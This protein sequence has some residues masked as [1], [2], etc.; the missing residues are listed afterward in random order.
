MRSVLS[1][2]V[3]FE[4]GIRLRTFCM[5]FWPR[6]RPFFRCLGLLFFVFMICLQEIYLNMCVYWLYVQIQGQIS[7]HFERSWYTYTYIHIQ[8]VSSRYL[9]PENSENLIPPAP[10][11]LKTYTSLH[12]PFPNPQSFKN[13]KQPTQFNKNPNNPQTFQTN[14][15]TN[16]GTKS[17]YF[18]TL[19]DSAPDYWFAPPRSA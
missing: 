10:Q 18:Q 1:S 11:I 7:W 9:T 8:G 12:L 17:S 2:D 19:P 3:G 14:S 13:P 5:N 6:D 16:P 15:K 4:L